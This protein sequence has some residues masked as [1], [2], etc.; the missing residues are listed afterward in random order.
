MAD[1]REV[2]M[3]KLVSLLLTQFP[4]EDEMHKTKPLSSLKFDSK[5]MK[6]RLD[7][8]IKDVNK[9]TRQMENIR[10]LVLRKLG[11]RRRLSSR[12]QKDENGVKDTKEGDKK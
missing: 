3:K 12:L 4:T 2:E 8:K 5:M 1:P 7:C 6:K 9:L 10:G 11:K